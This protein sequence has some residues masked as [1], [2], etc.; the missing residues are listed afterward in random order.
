[1][2]PR[3]GRTP[4]WLLALALLALLALNVLLLLA[5]PAWLE[6]VWFASVWPV[7]PAATALLQALVPWPITVL[8]LLLV[9][10]G[11]VAWAAWRPPRGRRLV[12]TL[13]VWTSLLAATF[14][15]AWG[16]A[17]RRVPVATTLAFATD[18]SQPETLLVALEQLV[19]RVGVDAPTRPLAL[20]VDRASL[21]DAVAAAA[22]CVA[23]TDAFVSG[24]RVALPR[25]VRPLPAGTLLRT[26]YAGISL[27]WLL[28]PHV[29]AGLP[30]ASWLAVAT[31]ELTHAAGWA[32]E[33]DTDALSV[34][35]GLRCDHAWVRYASALH[36]VRL[37]S[38]SL[39]P[40][41]S[42]GSA[43]QARM[44]SALAALP[45]VAHDDRAALRAAAERWYTP[46]VAHAVSRV[47]DG[48][49]RSQGVSDGIADYAAA[50][51]LV[52]AALA[53]CGSAS[54]A[55]WCH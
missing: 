42:A 43:D 52:G 4:S 14:V 11:L 28:E 47:Y 34:L 21:D 9:S 53:A 45:M 5:P 10:L 19:E 50:G 30:P 32:R 54:D 36:G 49:L 12:L 37:V 35:A 39:R 41:V 25:S 13:L 48:Y 29:D 27:P 38:T 8:V 17:Y 3:R 31:H 40:L 55:P 2:T 18:G 23:T 33:A 7:W 22:L 26:G 6:R 1:M 15:P 46:R 24:R 20:V 16:A 44:Q 51:A